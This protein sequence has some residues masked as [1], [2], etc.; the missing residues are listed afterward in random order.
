MSD[1][2]VG[3]LVFPRYKKNRESQGGVLMKTA[4]PPALFS[5][6]FTITPSASLYIGHFQPHRECLL[7][8][9]V[10][11]CSA[12]CL[13]WAARVS[14]HITLQLHHIPSVYLATRCPRKKNNSNMT[15]VS[16]CHP[17]IVSERSRLRNA[18]LWNYYF[19]LPLQWLL[20]NSGTRQHGGSGRYESLV[21]ESSRV[22]RKVR[23]S[24]LIRIRQSDSSQCQNSDRE[25][26][27]GAGG[28]TFSQRQEKREDQWSLPWPTDITPQL[29]KKK[30]SEKRGKN[31]ERKESRERRSEAVKTEFG[32]DTTSN[33]VNT[34]TQLEEKTQTHLRLQCFMRSQNLVT[35]TEYRHFY[36]CSF[37]GLSVIC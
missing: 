14:C 5:C 36:S 10:P 35:K 3:N 6:N 29:C 25:E 11:R 17:P 20:W 12:K 2:Q 23:L 21:C 9:I 33:K 4:S 13:E 15:T 1:K 27:R 31:L 26:G 7:L 16:L 18:K 32:G 19:L 30:Y 28:P 22:W 24:S 34:K 37:L 8:H